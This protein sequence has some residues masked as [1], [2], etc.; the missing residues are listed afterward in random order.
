MDKV[1]FSILLCLALCLISIAQPNPYGYKISGNGD[2]VSDAFF[3]QKGFFLDSVVNTSGTVSRT[4]RFEYNKQGRIK[5]DINFRLVITS[6]K[7][8]NRWVFVNMPGS[9]DYYYNEHGDVD[10]VSYGHWTLD[11]NVWIADSSGYKVHYSNDGKVLSIIYS[12][13]GGITEVIENSYDTTGNLTAIKTQDYADNITLQTNRD[14]DSL[15]RLTMQT[16][17]SSGNQSNYP[18]ENHYI[19]NYDSSGNINLVVTYKLNGDTSG[20]IHYFLQFD[21]FGKL[22]H[23]NIYSWDF[24]NLRWNQITEVVCQYDSFKR[25]QDMGGVAWFRYS[26]DGNLD[27]LVNVHLVYCGYLG[28]KATFIDSNQNTIVLPDCGGYNKL[29]YNSH[30]NEVKPEDI[31]IKSFALLQNYPNPFNPSTTIS[32]VLP[33]KS[34]V[35]LKIF[36]VLGR[37][38]TTLVHNEMLSAG[39]YS[40]QWNASAYCS[41][42]YFYRLQA[43]THLDTKKLIL[44]R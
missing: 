15:N 30:M 12:N 37:E 17:S 34:M 31:T 6:V 1:F 25:I 5:R 19:Y 21:E 20:I 7:I 39:T 29:Y 3:I 26:S 28:A 33:S 10:S 40:K 11:T 9:R 35:S 18:Y 2:I 44:L 14:Y 22:V 13:S 32:F 23:E 42:L 24:T 43:G 38:V 36:D 41:G 16:V 27:S 4:Y 8:N